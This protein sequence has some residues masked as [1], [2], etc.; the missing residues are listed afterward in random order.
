MPRD[1]NADQ[2]ADRAIQN[3][4]ARHA[5]IEGAY[6]SIR[7][8]L[9]VHPMRITEPELLDYIWERWKMPPQEVTA[10]DQRGALAELSKKLKRR[11]EISATLVTRYQSGTIAEI[12]AGMSL[13]AGPFED[14][15]RAELHFGW[16]EEKM[17]ERK[18]G[19][20]E[21]EGKSGLSRNTIRRWKSGKKSRRDPYVRGALAGAF[22]CKVADVP[23]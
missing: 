4:L 8:E 3:F 14:E 7:E 21:L 17:A 13:A 22:K 23:E 15:R 6:N 1:N 11:V 2:N 10:Q 20:K 12:P 16:L 5:N 9:T 18:W 19:M